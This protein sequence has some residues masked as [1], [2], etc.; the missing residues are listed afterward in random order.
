MGKLSSNLKLYT[1][2]LQPRSARRE[3]RLRETERHDLPSYPEAR[4]R[5]FTF[6]SDGRRVVLYGRKTAL[7]PPAIH[8]FYPEQGGGWAAGQE[9]Y[10]E[11]ASSPRLP[12]PCPH[13]WS[14]ELSALSMGRTRYGY[15]LVTCYACAD[16]KM[17]DV[18]RRH[19]Y[20]AHS[21]GKV[22]RVCA[23]QDDC[24][25]AYTFEPPY[26]VSSQ[27]RSPMTKRCDLSLRPSALLI[28]KKV[29]GADQGAG[30]QGLYV[31]LRVEV[32]YNGLLF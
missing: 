4:W 2:V 5:R 32:W 15:L 27:T 29:G 13:Q 7:T 8:V 6:L 9:P 16:I 20:V 24:V 17:V 31:L 11:Q 14:L 3:I 28:V 10:T 21:G 30:E 18:E 1:V 12:A 26:R 25:F 19:T 22:Q 23:V